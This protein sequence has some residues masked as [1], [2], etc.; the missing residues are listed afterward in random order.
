MSIAAV[1]SACGKWPPHGEG[2]T[3]YVIDRKTHIE[4]LVSRF[5]DS[6]FGRIDCQ[7]C[8]ADKPAAEWT[9]VSYKF[10]D[11]KWRRADNPR[12]ADFAK[13]FSDAGVTSVFRRSGGE[14]NLA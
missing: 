7:R 2:L 11:G 5:E 9:S 12:S 14:K 10:S 1:L 6:G 4:E 13:M 8:F 3:E